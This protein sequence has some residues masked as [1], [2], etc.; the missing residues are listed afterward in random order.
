MKRVKELKDFFFETIKYLCDKYNFDY[1]LSCPTYERYKDWLHRS[2]DLPDNIYFAN[3][4]SKMVIIVD[5]GYGL[6]WV[7]KIPFSEMQEDYCALEEK[8]YK[9]AVAHCVQ[10]A[11]AE[12]F[13]IGDYIL[14]DSK[15][16]IYLMVR[17]D[18]DEEEIMSYSSSSSYDSDSSTSSYYDSCINEEVVNCL[19]NFFSCEFIDRVIGFCEE[20]LIND[21]HDSNV[22]FCN[23]R[24]LIIDYSGYGG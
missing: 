11:F 22:G 20:F 18:T 17:A 16:K 8:Y 6:K 12:T 10:E 3:G 21:V 5:Y 9:E 19:C 7:V 4:L 14:E 15:C 13:C 2:D 1:F 23:G 24:P